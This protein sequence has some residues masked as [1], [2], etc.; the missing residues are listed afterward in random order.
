MAQLDPNLAAALPGVMAILDSEEGE[1][2]ATAQTL[3]IR[4]DVRR[5]RLN[6]TDVVA[7]VAAALI[8]RGHAAASALTALW[9]SNSAHAHA[10]IFAPALT[11]G[12]SD[13]TALPYG[14]VRMRPRY[15]PESYLAAAA[16]VGY[17]AESAFKLFERRRTAG[18]LMQ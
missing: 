8:G 5:W 13:M 14:G 1:L 11:V 16:M 4:G 10:A 6:T 3:G 17:I 12:L 7:D 18:R 2:Q 15:D 9:R